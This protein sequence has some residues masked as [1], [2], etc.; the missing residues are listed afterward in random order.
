MSILHAAGVAFSACACIVLL[1]DLWLLF[2]GH[3]NDDDLVMVQESED[4][5]ALNRPHGDDLT[6]KQH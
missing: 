2:T 6:T 3:M 5:A 4:L 1:L